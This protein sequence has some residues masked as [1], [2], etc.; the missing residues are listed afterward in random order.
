MWMCR[1][2]LSVGGMPIALFTKRMYIVGDSTLVCIP[3]RESGNENKINGIDG[4][5]YV[6][7]I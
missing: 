1:F 6:Y 3:T 5:F 4:L 7:L 2:K